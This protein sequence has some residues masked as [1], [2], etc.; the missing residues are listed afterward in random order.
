MDRYDMEML[1]E[2]FTVL[3]IV[4]IGI[5][6]IGLLIAGGIAGY[7]EGYYRIYGQAQAN[8]FNVTCK[9]HYTAEQYRFLDKE[10]AQQV[11]DKANIRV[12]EVKW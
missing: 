2:I 4:L 7:D 12:K 8:A 1:K 6:I 10:L 3:A 11:C 9:T 5:V